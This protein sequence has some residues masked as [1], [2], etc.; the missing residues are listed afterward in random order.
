MAHIKAVKTREGERRYVLI[1]RAPDGKQREQWFERRATAD[2]FRK[3]IESDLLRGMWI[4]PRSSAMTFEDWAKQWLARPGK[5]PSAHARDESIINVHLIPRIGK[6]ALRSITPQDV[7]SLVAAWTRRYKPRTVKRHYGVLRAILAAAVDCDMIGRT[8]CRA[9]RLPTPEPRATHVVDADELDRLSSA[10]G[11]RYAAMA[12]LGAVLGLRWGEVAGLR[13][14]AVRFLEGRLAVE[15]QIT[16][17]KGGRVVVGPPKSDAGRR[18]LTV[19]KALL[20][21]LS[22][23]LVARG[24]TAADADELIFPAPEGGPLDYS[25]WRRRVWLPA[26]AKANL[27]SLTFHD[28]RR[29]NATALVLGGVDLKTA[30]TRLGHSD[31]RLTLAVYAQASSDADRLASDH[32][33]AHFMAPVTLASG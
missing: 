24:L 6:R 27:P 14:G 26:C 17:G 5:R 23:L 13:V 16:R 28:L 9:V 12:Y 21:M 7:Q 10:L 29:A 15:Q 8:P 22:A 18:T 30:Q 1:Y 32:L 3:T 31:P 19:P 33:G 2:N 20:D 4:D 25:C 11:P